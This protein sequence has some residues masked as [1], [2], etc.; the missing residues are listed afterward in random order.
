MEKVMQE[1]PRQP[2]NSPSG[3]SLGTTPNPPK[4][5]EKGGRNVI[6]TTSG[7]SSQGSQLSTNGVEFRIS[8]TKIN[9]RPAIS[10]P[11]ANPTAVR[12]TAARVRSPLHRRRTMKGPSTPLARFVSHKIVA[13]KLASAKK[14]KPMQS[15][16]TTEK[17]LDASAMAVKPV[18]RTVQSRP[19]RS[20]TLM[21]PTSSSALKNT[22]KANERLVPQLS[23]TTKGLPIKRT[24]SP[25]EG[26][27]ADTFSTMDAALPRR[28]AS[29]TTSQAASSVKTVRK[30]VPSTVH[31]ARRLEVGQAAG[32]GPRNAA[33]TA[34]WR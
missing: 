28:L 21:A 16:G 18:A 14:P 23:S 31:T 24:R 4:T 17:E 9:T 33:Q 11:L 6:D 12:H 32:V 34:T 29:S 2:S 15:V 13:E 25:L 10:S 20:T 5:P 27:A 26:S 8:P 22:T 30:D 7:E 3:V 1:P 19:P